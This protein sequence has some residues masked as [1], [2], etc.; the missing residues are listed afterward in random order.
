[1]E[2]FAATESKPW[3]VYMLATCEDPV[4][5][6]VGATI[7]VDRRLTNKILT[8]YTETVYTVTGTTPALSPSNG[9]IQLWT[10]SAS[11]VPAIGTWGNGQ[12]L[13]LMIDDGASS[14]I[15]W[16]SM[17]ITWKT[18]NGTAPTLNTTGYT[19]IQ[20]WKVN[21]IMYGARVGNA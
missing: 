10:L 2:P 6:Y 14:T 19:V 8:G 11:S 4:R 18:D 3:F 12:S 7:D 20:L 13:T 9:T 15:S 1:M 21:N 5:T 17:S 16:A